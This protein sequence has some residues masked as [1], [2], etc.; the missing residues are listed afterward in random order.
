MK[1][2]ALLALFF[3]GAVLVASPLTLLADKTEDQYKHACGLLSQG[4]FQG[5]Q[6]EFEAI[7]RKKHNYG[8]A[9]V[10]LGVTLTKLS[11]Q[12]EK[13]GDRTRAVAQL[14]EALRLDL[15]EAYWH[16]ALA[17]LLNAQGFAEEAAKERSQAAQLS[18][19]DSGLA[20]AGGFAVSP[21]IKKES[22]TNP[23]AKAPARARPLQ[24]GGGVTEPVPI[25]KP[26]PSYSEKARKA[27]YQGTVV[28]W[29]VVDAQGD[30]EQQTVVK[31]L[32]LGLDERALRTVRTWKF[33]PA[34]RNGTPVPVRVMVE[35]SFR[36]F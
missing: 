30:V 26:D 32:G 20:G 14:R 22:G 31:P 4:D 16:S 15:D 25:E 7:L 10:L 35:V 1:E 3:Y 13:H 23:E 12:S 17:K 2:N 11:E 8:S 18:P 28:L 5:A 34:A 33:K 21:D 36:L 19:D 24:V 6:T 27:R 29:I 9:K